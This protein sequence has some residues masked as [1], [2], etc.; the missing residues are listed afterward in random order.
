MRR[1]QKGAM[2]RYNEL[3]IIQKLN[4]KQN[5]KPPPLEVLKGNYLCLYGEYSSPYKR[6]YKQLQT[7]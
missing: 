5:M 3:T 7:N 2:L 1:K 4:A 6:Q